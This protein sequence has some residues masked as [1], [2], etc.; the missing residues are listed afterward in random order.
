MHFYDSRFPRNDFGS[1]L[2]ALDKTVSGNLR[3][4][5]NRRI[6]KL[7]SRTL[8]YVLDRNIGFSRGA[9]GYRIVHAIPS[10]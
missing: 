5:S 3:R 4:A 6:Q 8:S 2:V 10:R 9:F 1:G 7:V